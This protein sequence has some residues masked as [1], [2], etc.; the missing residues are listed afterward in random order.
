[1]H[2][3]LILL[4]LFACSGQEPESERLRKQNQQGEFI[5]RMHEET[6]FTL[7]SPQLQTPSLYPWEIGK[8]SQY[9]KITKEFFRCKGSQQNPAHIVQVKKKEPLRFFDCGG[10][11]KHSLPLREGKEFVYPVLIDL[12]NYI[13]AKTHKRVVITSGHRCPDHN[14]YV[15]NSPENSCSKHM[16]AAEVSFYVQGMEQHP[17]EV[18]QH[19][20]NYYKET[21]KYKGQKEY[22]EFKR[23]EKKDT[24]VSTPPWSNKEIF[25]KLFQAK[26]GRNF[27][28]RHLFP[29]LDIQ[30]RFDWDLQEKVIYSWEKANRNYQRR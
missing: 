14:A 23:Y 25:V 3:L 5:Y 7:A 24:N 26:E 27:D 1:M 16:L 21:P 12:L 9:P 11:E 8:S 2:Y 17:E 13:Q 19:I 6:F 15:D 28:N 30:V 20:F 29:Y 18:L 10:S 4:L 22:E